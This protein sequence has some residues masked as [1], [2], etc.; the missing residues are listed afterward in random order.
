MDG[1][2]TVADASGNGLGRAE[3]T[4]DSPV[5]ADGDRTR[6]QGGAHGALS[7]RGESGRCASTWVVPQDE[8][9]VPMMGRGFFILHGEPERRKGL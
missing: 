5:A 7:V 8:S 3:R 6:Y 4:A 1:G 9:L 2:I